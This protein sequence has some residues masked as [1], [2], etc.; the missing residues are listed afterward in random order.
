MADDARA[1][2]PSWIGMRHTR[3]PWL[4]GAN[5]SNSPSPYGAVAARKRIDL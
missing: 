4:K 5:H 2:K 3:S 1:D